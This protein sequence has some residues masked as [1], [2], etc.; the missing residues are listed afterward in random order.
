MW[1]SAILLT[2]AIISGSVRG[3]TGI[4]RAVDHEIYSVAKNSPA[5]LAG[6]HKGDRVL[7][8]DEQTK[9]DIDGPAGT[10]VRLELKR[11]EKILLFYIKRVPHKEAYND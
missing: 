5:D 10:F 4:R 11:G 1:I 8:I 3:Y 2:G 7:T 9:G 6:V